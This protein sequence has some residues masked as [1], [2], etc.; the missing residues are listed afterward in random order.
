MA[1]S[2][3]FISDIKIKNLKRFKFHSIGVLQEQRRLHKVPSIGKHLESLSRIENR[4][5]VEKMQTYGTGYRQECIEKA[6]GGCGLNNATGEEVD[7][8]P[9][10]S[11]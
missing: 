3:C 1:S 6:V 10:H 11:H 9:D 7:A 4:D 5:P 2:G 8:S